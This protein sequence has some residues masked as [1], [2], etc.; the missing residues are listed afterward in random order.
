MGER[1]VVM[2]IER[3]MAVLASGVVLLGV[4][5]TPSAGAEGDRAYWALDESG[6]PAVAF[7]SIGDNDGT[8]F[9]IQGTGEGYI[10]NG[11]S[12]R[13]VVP[14][15]ASLNPGDENFSYGATIIMNQSPPLKDTD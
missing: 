9:N 12:S 11:V 1:G 13:V 4:A 6:T 2:Y 7:D 15:D 5:A 10:F 14:S 3:A 8:N